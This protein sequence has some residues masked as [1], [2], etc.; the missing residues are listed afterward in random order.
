MDRGCCLSQHR[1]EAAEVIGPVDGNAIS[2]EL[3]GRAPQDVGVMQEGFIV[4]QQDPV[5]FIEN[6]LNTSTRDHEGLELLIAGD[7][8]QDRPQVQMEIGNVDGDDAVRLQMFTVKVEGFDSEQVDRDGVSSEGIQD[9]DIEL[10]GAFVR[11]TLQGD[12]RAASGG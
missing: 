1:E 12:R 8:T 3:C 4:R 6:F 10:V 9:E 5:R 7:A 2:R 11:R